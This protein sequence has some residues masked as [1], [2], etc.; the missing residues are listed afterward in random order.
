MKRNSRPKFGIIS[1]FHNNIRVKGSGKITVHLVRNTTLLYH[2]LM[3]QALFLITILLSFSAFGASEDAFNKRA[4]AGGEEAVLSDLPC[5]LG[6]DLRI[7]SVGTFLS[8]RQHGY[9]SH[10][11]FFV[12]FDE[13]NILEGRINQIAGYKHTAHS[14]EGFNRFGMD[15]GLRG[16]TPIKVEGNKIT[17]VDDANEKL[18][19]TKKGELLRV[20]YK[21]G[22]RR[23]NSSCSIKL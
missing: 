19:L 23:T 13:D 9:F 8:L 22:S 6:K 14:D 12:S 15:T 17:I 5:L 10:C 18:V 7:D 16:N 11:V 20:H 2:H 21:V 1:S 3:K 4:C